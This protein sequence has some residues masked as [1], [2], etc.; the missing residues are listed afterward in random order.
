[1]GSGWARC[2]EMATAA[3]NYVVTAHK[4]T[5][6]TACATGEHVFPF[7]QFVWLNK[8]IGSFC[9]CLAASGWNRHGLVTIG[10]LFER[11]CL[12]WLK[13][14]LRLGKVFPS[15]VRGKV[16]IHQLTSLQLVNTNSSEI[17]NIKIFGKVKKT[18]PNFNVSSYQHLKNG[19]ISWH[20]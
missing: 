14:T 19:P 18:L 1:M 7:V 15:P 8:L 20:W 3:Y 11:Q 16:C 2:A 6:V 5:A 10:P 17:V 4:P 13:V 9:S 12:C